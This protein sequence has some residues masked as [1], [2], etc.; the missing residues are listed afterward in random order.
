MLAGEADGSG[1]RMA[2]K[3]CVAARA[4]RGKCCPYA[5]KIPRGRARL[6]TCGAIGHSRCAAIFAFLDRAGIGHALVRE[7]L[8]GR[9]SP[10]STSSGN[11]TIT[12][13]KIKPKP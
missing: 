9:G 12:N 6:C 13:D 1:R 8:E 2:G 11:A 4:C 10:K 3:V 7:V 5:G